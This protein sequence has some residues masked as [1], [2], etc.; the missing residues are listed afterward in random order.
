[1][2][3]TPINPAAAIEQTLRPELE[4]QVRRDMRNEPSIEAV[5]QEIAHRWT[6]QADAIKR[7]TD[8]EPII[9]WEFKIAPADYRANTQYK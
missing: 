5:Y 1:M 8:Q 2:S 7:L 3:A 4:K 9:C 6:R